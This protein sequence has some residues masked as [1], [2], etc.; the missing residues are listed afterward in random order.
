MGRDPGRVDDAPDLFHHAL[1]REDDGLEGAHVG[2]GEEHFAAT[3]GRAAALDH[4]EL[5]IV[6]H[7]ELFQQG[8]RDRAENINPGILRVIGDTYRY[9]S[10]K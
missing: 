9:E 3:E 2:A 5:D 8:D 1:L 4:F 10:G 6:I 7:P